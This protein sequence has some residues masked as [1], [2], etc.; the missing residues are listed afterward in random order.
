MAADD[1]VGRIARAQSQA[2]EIRRR[3]H[4]EYDHDEPDDNI[5]SS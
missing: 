4:E 1:A 2:Q 5:E 3:E